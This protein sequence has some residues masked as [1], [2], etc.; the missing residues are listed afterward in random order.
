MSSQSVD[1]SSTDGSEGFY[2]AVSADNAPSEVEVGD[3]VENCYK[4]DVRGTYPAQTTI[5]TARIINE[6]PTKAELTESEVIREALSR[7][8]S[9]QTLAIKSVTYNDGQNTWTIILKDIFEGDEYTHD[10]LDE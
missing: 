3:L 6:Q 7:Q 10:I 1:Y 4:G 2:D 5:Q 8:S 9:E